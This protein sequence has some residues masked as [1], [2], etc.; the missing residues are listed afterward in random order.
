[1][2]LKVPHLV[3]PWAVS[4]SLEKGILPASA[5]V[6]MVAILPVVMLAFLV[7][8][9]AVVIL[10]F[11]AFRNERRCAPRAAELAPDVLNYAQ[12]EI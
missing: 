1:L 7:F 2:W 10:V 6:F 4:A 9:S 3:N 8:A 12:G 11:V 5:M